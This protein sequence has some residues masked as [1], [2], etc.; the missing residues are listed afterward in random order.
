M[1]RRE[2]CSVRAFVDIESVRVEVFRF[3]STVVDTS[4]RHPEGKPESQTSATTRNAQTPS[5]NARPSLV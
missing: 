2:P 3:M 5:F 1:S 4:H